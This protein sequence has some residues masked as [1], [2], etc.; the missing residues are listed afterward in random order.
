ML[1]KL[2]NQRCSKLHAPDDALPTTRTF[3][4]SLWT[5]ARRFKSLVQQRGEHAVLDTVFHETSL[6]GAAYFLTAL[7]GQTRIAASGPKC[8][9]KLHVQAR[10]LAARF[11]C[12]CEHHPREINQATDPLYKLAPNDGRN[13]LLPDDELL[14]V[15]E[16]MAADFGQ[17]FKT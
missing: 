2:W 7:L 1:W 3:G 17:I 15:E 9:K 10:E 14:H 5:R 11:T 16:L 6:A 12:T 4:S 8:S 13:V